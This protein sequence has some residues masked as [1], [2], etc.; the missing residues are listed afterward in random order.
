MCIDGIT[1]VGHTLDFKT[2]Y[3]I[4]NLGHAECSNFASE[5]SIRSAKS[6]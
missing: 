4:L 5:T 6:S 3:N 2:C 1:I